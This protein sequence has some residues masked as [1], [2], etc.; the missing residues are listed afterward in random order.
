MV[1]PAT[2]GGDVERL[3]EPVPDAKLPLEQAVE[4]ASEVCR[5]VPP[6]VWQWAYFTMPDLPGNAAEPTMLLHS[7]HIQVES[8]HILPLLC[9]TRQA[10]ECPEIGDPHSVAVSPDDPPG[11]HRFQGGGDLLSVCPRHCRHVALAEPRRAHPGGAA[12]QYRRNPASGR[13]TLQGHVKAAA[14]AALAAR[15]E[16]GRTPAVTG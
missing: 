10:S 5:V 7:W 2:P 1:Q 16:S 3:T 15:P 13:M 6:Q 9:T 11:T 12:Q 14:R 8:L 4:T